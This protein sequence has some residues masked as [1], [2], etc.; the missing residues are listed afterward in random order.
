MLNVMELPEN[1]VSIA[2]VE[3][4]PIGICAGLIAIFLSELAPWTFPSQK[5]HTPAIK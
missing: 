5:Q 4:R 1:V 2:A 3:S